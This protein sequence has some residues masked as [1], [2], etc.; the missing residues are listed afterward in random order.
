MRARELCPGQAVLLG[1]NGALVAPVTGQAAVRDV[2][3]EVYGVCILST[4]EPTPRLP[5]SSAP[6]RQFA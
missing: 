1:G 5:G 2:F 6:A 4:T 3:N